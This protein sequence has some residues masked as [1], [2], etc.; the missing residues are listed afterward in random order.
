M[1]DF[2]CVYIAKISLSKVIWCVFTSMYS[3]LDEY[4]WLKFVHWLWNAYQNCVAKHNFMNIWLLYITPHDRWFMQYPEE[5]MYNNHPTIMKKWSY[6]TFTLASSPGSFPLSTCRRKEPGNIGGFKPLTS[7]GAARVPPIRLQNEIT[8][9][10]DLKFNIALSINTHVEQTTWI[11]RPPRSSKA[12]A[13][14]AV[15]PFITRRGK[16][17]FQ[18]LAG[19]TESRSDCRKYRGLWS[20]E[21]TYLISLARNV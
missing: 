8:W 15:K 19:G 5:A 16:P 21:M 2:G 17:C 18:M 4:S 9:K 11:W 14:C 3:W 7:S 10:C 6:T 13:G 1:C 20:V 12:L